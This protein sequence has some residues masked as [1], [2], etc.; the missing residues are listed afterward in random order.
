MHP[1]FRAG[2]EQCGVE[3]NPECP[4]NRGYSIDRP[5]LQILAALSGIYF[6]L[7]DQP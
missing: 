5:C 3:S 2:S 1:S 7:A 6:I 4:L